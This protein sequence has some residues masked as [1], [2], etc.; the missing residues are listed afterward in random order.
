MFLSSASIYSMQKEKVWILVGWIG[1]T[2]EIDVKRHYVDEARWVQFNAAWLEKWIL[3]GHVR[4][5]S[6]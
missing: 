1:A 5:F 4:S 3:H 6:G 2:T